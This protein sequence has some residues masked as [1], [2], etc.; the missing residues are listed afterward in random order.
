MTVCQPVCQP[1]GILNKNFCSICICICFIYTAPQACSY[2]YK[3]CINKV[4][5]PF[6]FYNKIHV[7]A[8]PLICIRFQ[9]Y[10][11]V[12]SHAFV[13]FSPTKKLACFKI[14]IAFGS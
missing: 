11:R 9:S 14:W 1:V 3:P 10:V 8:T 6:T 4:A 7:V 2:K 13:M 5:L 12:K